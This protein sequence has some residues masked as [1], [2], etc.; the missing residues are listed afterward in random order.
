MRN[1]TPVHICMTY[2]ALREGNLIVF[3][4][5]ETCGYAWQICQLRKLRVKSDGKNVL[6]LRLYFVLMDCVWFPL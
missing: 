5:T 3:N 1:V 4:L 2:G 6:E